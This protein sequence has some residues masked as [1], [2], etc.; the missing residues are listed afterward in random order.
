M[1]PLTDAQQR[2]DAAL[3][4]LIER[5]NALGDV[6]KRGPAGAGIRQQI[7]DMVRQRNGDAAARDVSD[8]LG[9]TTIRSTPVFCV[10]ILTADFR[11]VTLHPHPHPHP[12]HRPHPPR[13]PLRSEPMVCTPRRRETAG[14]GCPATRRCRGCPTPMMRG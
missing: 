13:L 12:P 10:R 3:D 4:Q 7:T 8:T 2:T 6:Q 9:R 11:A 5:W 1:P 14:C